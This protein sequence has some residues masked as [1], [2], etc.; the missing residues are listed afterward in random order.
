MNKLFGRTFIKVFC[1]IKENIFI[2]TMEKNR[3]Y[4]AGNNA[5]IKKALDT[6]C[7]YIVISNPDVI[8]YNKAI[9]RLIAMLESR[10]ESRSCR[11]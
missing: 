7:E 6:G 3:G 11:T 10:K 9:D 5:G 4:A 8:F 2:I 1:K